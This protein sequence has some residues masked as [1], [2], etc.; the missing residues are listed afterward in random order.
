MEFAPSPPTRL[1]L[2]VSG[3][4]LLVSADVPEPELFSFLAAK[5]LDPEY[6]PGLGVSA[7]ARLLT[8][9][10]HLDV[11]VSVSED[12]LPIWTLAC[13][14][15]APEFPATVERSGANYVLSWESQDGMP[16]DEIVPKSLASLL[17]FADL[18]L[19]ATDDVWSDIERNLPTLGPSGTASIT[20]EGFIAIKTSKPQI[21]E[22]SKIPG[23]FRTSSTSFGVCSA[24]AEELLREPG[25]RWSGPRPVHKSPAIE[26]PSHLSLAPHVRTALPQL[27]SDLSSFGAKAVVW[28]SGLGRRILVLAA[29]EI[30]DAYPATV[31]CPPQSLW[32]WMRHVDMVNRTFGLSHDHSDVQLITYHD[33]P[34]RRVEAQSI[35]FDDLDSPEAAASWPALLR[36]QYLTDAYRLAVEDVWPDDLEDSRRLMEILRPGEFR[37]DQSIA[38]RYPVDP[39][40]RLQEHVE[41][42][43][44]RRSRDETPDRRVFR[45]SSVRVVETTQA[46]HVAI[47]AA[48]ARITST[49]PQRVLAEVM[50]MVSA[51][52][53]TSLSP[54][55]AVAL[56]MTR[57][58]I[59]RGRSV[60]L[61]TRHKRTAQLL[62]SLL[63][64]VQAT[65]L[66]GPPADAEVDREPIVVL[67]FDTVLPRLQAFDDVIMVDYPWTF[68]VLEH[69]VSPAQVSE[70]P[71]V[72][73]IHA[74]NS[75]DDRL[76]VL[77]ARRSEYG[78]TGPEVFHLSVDDIAYVLAPR[79]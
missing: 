72:V 21:L 76:A 26:F 69:A 4:T 55:V 46:Q 74:A 45:R 70:G 18:A 41:V 33:L 71:D 47:A 16:Y 30:L 66:D 10:A 67:R 15:P 51:G 31:L 57:S 6:R 27:V 29:L 22:A 53:A 1:H 11:R 7:P 64:P 38:E 17:G 48:S 19:V 43:L 62:R 59:S 50:E 5:A 8:K 58:A 34:F 78:S 63:R 2:D 28:E 32:L 13:H 75:P 20:P 54:K 60:A 52:P 37:T 23:L 73:M 40:R 25:L 14:P 77:A 79:R 44:S 49:A 36:L 35:I 24:F 42:Y 39:A 3:L 9:F 65:M 56:E 68:Q 12:L 61:V